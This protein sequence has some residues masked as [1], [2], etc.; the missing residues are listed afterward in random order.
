MCHKQACIV[1]SV[2]NLLS[3]VLLIFALVAS[4]G[5]T[6]NITP[7]RRGQDILL[8]S[9]Y[10]NMYFAS[11]LDFAQGLNVENEIQ[12]DSTNK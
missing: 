10:V 11:S 7:E 3:S 1:H 6:V 4:Q 5:L 2:G 12:F 8:Y 9:A